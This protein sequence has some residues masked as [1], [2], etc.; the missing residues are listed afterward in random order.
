MATNPRLSP[1]LFCMCACSLLAAV[2]GCQRGQPQNADT[3]PPVIPVSHPVEQDVTDYVD[4][5]G[6]VDAVDSVGIRARVTG[7]LTKMPFKEGAE[8]KK[9]DLLF[10]IDPRPYQFQY[11]Q[12]QSQVSLYQAQLE[13]TQTTLK[14]Y[15]ALDKST[16]STTS[17]QELD[18]YRASDVE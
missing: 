10:E 14:R 2:A 6:R 13:L 16:P 11:D 3:G 5:T 18:Q 1:S 15:D 9:G 7:Y 8:V 17:K 4:Y 12:A